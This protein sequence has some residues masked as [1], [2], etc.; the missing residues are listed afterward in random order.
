MVLFTSVIS[1]PF[2]L[3]KTFPSKMLSNSWSLP[4]LLKMDSQKSLFILLWVKP[5]IQKSFEL[6]E[7]ICFC[8]TSNLSIDLLPHQADGID[9]DLRGDFT[10][11]W[12]SSPPLDYL[13]L[14]QKRESIIV[15]LQYWW[16]RGQWRRWW[17]VMIREG[18]GPIVNIGR[19]V[20]NDSGPNSC[21]KEKSSYGC[22]LD[23]PHQPTHNIVFNYSRS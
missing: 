16:W 20:I 13:V 22:F 5:Q 2:L 23:H 7:F 18:S 3:I 11:T 19:R 17:W 9:Q 21:A 12:K 14:Y 4:L 8:V 10:G 1:R 15:V 6:W